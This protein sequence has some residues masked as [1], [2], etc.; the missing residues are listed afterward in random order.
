LQINAPAGGERI[1]EEPV[2]PVRNQELQIKTRC[3]CAG[4][5]GGGCVRREH[6]ITI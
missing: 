5:V 1:I 4:K 6:G 3:P 2:H